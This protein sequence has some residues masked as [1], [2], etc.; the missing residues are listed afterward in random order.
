MFTNIVIESLSL[1]SNIKV[2]SKLLALDA[3]MKEGCEQLRGV[4]FFPRKNVFLSHGTTDILDIEQPGINFRTL[5]H[6]LIH[7]ALAA[8]RLHLETFL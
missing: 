5:S 1:A 7:G 3:A 4:C 2:I 8:K 6:F